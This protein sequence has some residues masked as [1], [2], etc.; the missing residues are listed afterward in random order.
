MRP[1]RYYLSGLNT[2]GVMPMKIFSTFPKIQG[3]ETHN[4]IL[5]YIMYGIIVGVV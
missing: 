1:N 2:P 4:H 5:F 3:L